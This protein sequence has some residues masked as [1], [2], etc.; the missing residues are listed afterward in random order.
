[1]IPYDT[2][3]DLVALRNPNYFVPDISFE[4]AV[5]VRNS[6]VPE[7]LVRRGLEPKLPPPPPEPTP[8]Q[9]AVMEDLITQQVKAM[10]LIDRNYSQGSDM[11]AGIGN[12]ELARAM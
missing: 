1:M 11:G 10:G 12:T 9:N 4:E 5:D 2:A 6:R 8:E 3:V 7:H